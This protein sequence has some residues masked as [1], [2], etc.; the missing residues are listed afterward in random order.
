[1]VRGV[2]LVL[3]LFW[4]LLAFSLQANECGKCVS[5]CTKETKDQPGLAALVNA[6]GKTSKQYCRE[7][8]CKKKCSDNKQIEKDAL[9]KH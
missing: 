6:S 3:L 1:M 2:R 8:Y 5:D 7:D 9:D 4:I